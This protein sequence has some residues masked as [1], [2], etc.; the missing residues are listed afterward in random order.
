MI[1]SSV[2]LKHGTINKNTGLVFWRYEQNG[3]EKWVTEDQFKSMREQARVNA[4]KRYWSN[5]E[6]SRATLREWHHA[7]KNKKSKSF[8]NWSEKNQQ[9]IR[10]NRLMRQYGLS[11]EDYIAMYESQ[12]SLCAICNESQQGI[13]K[14]GEE[15]FLCVDHCHKTGKVRGLLCARCNA[16][17]GQF[18][19][20]P[21]FLINASKYLVQTQGMQQ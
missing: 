8:K 20:N 2:R 10:G 4:K 21:E 5:V 19:D 15:R 13:T 9:R 12:L 3:K 11:N 6:Q 17:L 7:N 18:Q 14:D 1:D 16:G